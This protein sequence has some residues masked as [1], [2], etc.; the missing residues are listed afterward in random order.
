MNNIVELD[1]NSASLYT[2][3]KFDYTDGTT[4]VIPII[5][6]A[7]TFI[8]QYEDWGG[9][10]SI[11]VTFNRGSNLCRTATPGTNPV[12]DSGAPIKTKTIDYTK[13]TL[14]GKT[15]TIQFGGVDPITD[16]T[17]TPGSGTINFTQLSTADIAT[18]AAAQQTTLSTYWDYNKL[19]TPVTYTFKVVGLVQT[20]SDNK[21]YIPASFADTLM[22]KY[23]QN[24][25]S[26]RNTTAIPT[27][28]LNS[29]YKGLT[30]DGTQ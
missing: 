16:Y 30:Y 24:Q 27:T 7:N 8:Q 2:T 13:D 21:T 23:I 25:L 19:N 20:D 3:E 14:I 18:K 26:A 12:A 1:P 9:K 15:F 28:V 29:T 22:N 17:V 11:D 5:L 6:N 10:T 4:T